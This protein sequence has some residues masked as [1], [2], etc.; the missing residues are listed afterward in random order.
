MNYQL[1]VI[2]F[3]ANQ[4]ASFR[5]H[6]PEKAVLTP[7]SP[8]MVFVLLVTTLSSSAAAPGFPLAVPACVH[9]SNALLVVPEAAEASPRILAVQRRQLS[10]L[11]VG[12]SVIIR[13]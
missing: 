13:A 10:G 5:G 6:L 1:K 3:L 2:H 8:A 12:E 4:S 9:T 11:N 7:L